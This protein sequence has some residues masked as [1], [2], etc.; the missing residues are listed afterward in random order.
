[1]F[2]EENIQTLLLNGGTFTLIWLTGRLL[3]KL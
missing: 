3:Q 1:M 2:T